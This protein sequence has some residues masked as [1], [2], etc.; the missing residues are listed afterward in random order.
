METPKKCST[1]LVYMENTNLS[2]KA[3]EVNILQSSN[4]TG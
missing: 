3:D 4:A 1:S 2:S